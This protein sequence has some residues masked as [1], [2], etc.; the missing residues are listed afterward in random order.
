MNVF[1][2][3]L[4]SSSVMQ[5]VIITPIKLIIVQF[6]KRGLFLIIKIKN[7]FKNKDINVKKIHLTDFQLVILLIQITV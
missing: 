1:M 3:A 2:E 6:V 7:A 4:I 5:L